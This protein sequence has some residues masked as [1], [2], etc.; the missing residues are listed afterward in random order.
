MLKQG[1]KTTRNLFEHVHYPN[2][3]PVQTL[4]NLVPG[5]YVFGINAK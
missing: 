4:C 5:A 1:V 3:C 2:F